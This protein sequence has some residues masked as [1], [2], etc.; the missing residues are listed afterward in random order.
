ML[1]SDT[2]I[3]QSPNAAD[4]S[5]YLFPTNLFTDQHAWTYDD[6]FWTG[7]VR[8]TVVEP[9]V[10][11]TKSLLLTNT[12]PHVSPEVLVWQLCKYMELAIVYILHHVSSKLLW[13]WTGD[14]R[15]FLL[16]DSSSVPVITRR[17]DY[18]RNYL[19]QRYFPLCFIS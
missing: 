9:K 13:L 10:K 12:L 8:W 15:S 7:C 17:F 11:R 5:K 14:G 18:N 19:W 16:D 6:I 1:V 4:V 2:T 3:Q